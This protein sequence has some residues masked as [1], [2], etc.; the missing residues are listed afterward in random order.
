MCLDQEHAMMQCN[1]YLQILLNCS[2]LFVQNLHII[3]CLL[4]SIIGLPVITL[5][6]QGGARLSACMGCASLTP[7]G[8]NLTCTCT[9][10]NI[11]PECK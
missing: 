4:L 3:Y 11:L 7:T 2:V 6:M 9:S 10:V 5:P 1:G 8:A